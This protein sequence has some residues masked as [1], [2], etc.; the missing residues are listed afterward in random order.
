MDDVDEKVNASQRV[1]HEV[2]TR[3]RRALFGGDDPLPGHPDHCGELTLSKT[4][5]PTPFTQNGAEVS[6]AS[7]DHNHSKCYPRLTFR[8][9]STIGYIDTDVNHE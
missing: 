9:M 4:P 5:G 6:G 1:E 8:I 3:G 2:H 7:R